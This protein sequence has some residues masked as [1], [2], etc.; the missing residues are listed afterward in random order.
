MK[1]LYPDFILLHNMEYPDSILLWMG[2]VT[3]GLQLENNH[4]GIDIAT[5]NQDNVRVPVAGR[6]VYYGIS[7]EFG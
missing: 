7:D 4:L 5:K 1:I 6:V 3:R 2:Y